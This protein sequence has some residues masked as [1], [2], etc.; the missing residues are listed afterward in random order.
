MTFLKQFMIFSELNDD[1]F[2]QRVYQ[3]R[4]FVFMEG[5]EREAAF[6]IKFG[7]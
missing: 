4:M 7:R 5:E 6:F 2:K 1:E 3:P